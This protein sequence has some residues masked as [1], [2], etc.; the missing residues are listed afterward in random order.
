[1]NIL[2]V[3]AGDIGFQLTKRL[4]R[5]HD[6]TIVDADPKRVKRAADQ[7]DSLVIEGHGASNAV[8]QQAGI[9]KTDIV[10][11]MT[12]DDEVNLLA[13]LL[14]KKAGVPVTVARV[15]NPEFTMPDFPL[16]AEELGVDY[17]IHPEKETA[18]AIVKLLG[19]THATDVVDFEEGRIRL[20]GVR[21][22]PGSE[23]LHT[24]LMHLVRQFGDPP[25]R[26]V[27]INRKQNTVIPK[28]NHILEA[29]DQIFGICAP[30]YVDEFLSHTGHGAFQIENVMIL[31]GGLVGQFVATGLDKEIN[32]KVVESNEAR[33]HEIANVLSDAL[34]IHGD[35]TDMDLLAAEGLMDM[36][37]FVSVTGDDETNIISTLLAR[38]LRVPRTIAQVNKFEYLPITATLGVDAIVSK[39]L[40]TVNAVHRYILH[41][42]V[43]AVA[44]VPGINAHII[45]FQAEAGDKILKK[46]LKDTKFPDDAIIGAILR[47][48]EV[49][50]PRGDTQVQPGDRVVVFS[51]PNCLEDVRSLFN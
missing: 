30:D 10:T 51:L 37:A 41:Q 11:A 14:A 44:S 27:A 16:S 7:L 2:I 34:I 31:G 49:L 17:F 43:E 39:Q 21:L 35:G 24:P 5:R 45:E 47:G 26:I 28:G 38:H 15:R 3:G 22:E 46:P 48:E 23:L 36:D 32:V 50:I 18:D 13:C 42:E 12:D 19:E 29:G 4:S 6:M 25:M 8:L 40:L 9:S 33:S 20:V 1:M